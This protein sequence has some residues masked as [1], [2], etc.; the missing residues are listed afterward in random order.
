L[1]SLGALTAE[2]FTRDLGGSFPSIRD[3]MLHIL[4]GEWIWL[5]YWKA[6]HHDAAFLAELRK[7]REALFAPDAFRDADALRRKW[8]EVEALQIEF[9]RSVSDESLQKMIPARDTLLSLAHLMQHMA[10]HSTYHRGQISLMMRQLGAEPV[11][12]DFHVFLGERALT[13]SKPA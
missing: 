2:Q 12:T 3:T 6:P 7:R 4:A 5:N 10:N 8:A 11:A 1:R 9:V 13:V